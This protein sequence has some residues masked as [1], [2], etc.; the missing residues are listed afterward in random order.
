M[1]QIVVSVKNDLKKMLN[2]FEYG[3]KQQSKKGIK[4]LVTF[5]QSVYEFAV[6]ETLDKC[7]ISSIL[8]EIFIRI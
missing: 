8:N 3:V 5:S 4:I 2:I 7:G 6:S 1:V